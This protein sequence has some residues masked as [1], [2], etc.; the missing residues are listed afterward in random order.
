VWVTWVNAGHYLPP[1]VNPRVARLGPRALVA[2]GIEHRFPNPMLRLSPQAD[3]LRLSLLC[4]YMPVAAERCCGRLLKISPA[5]SS[6]SNQ[7]ATIAA[8]A[9]HDWGG[10]VL[11]EFGAGLLWACLFVALLAL[12]LR[13]ARPAASSR[14]RDVRRNEQQ[15]GRRRP[16]CTSEGSRGGRSGSPLPG[17]LWGGAG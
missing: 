10:F 8:V 5:C 6:R 17:W 13:R 11:A 9:G 3:D 15:T 14:R 12:R 2:Q 7:L 1:Q 16:W 4:L